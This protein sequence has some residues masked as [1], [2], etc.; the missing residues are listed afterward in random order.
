MPVGVFIKLLSAYHL[1]RYDSGL[2]FHKNFTELV[3]EVK[4]SLR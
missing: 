1:S 2:Y 4:D 3:N